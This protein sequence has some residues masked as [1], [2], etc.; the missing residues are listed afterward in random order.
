MFK[1]HFPYKNIRPT[2]E[3]ILES[4][5]KIYNSPKKYRYIVIEAGTGI[6]KSALAKSISNKEG[7]AYLLTATKQLQDQYVDDFGMMGA[8]AVKGADNYRCGVTENMTCG[9][10]ECVYDG[11]LRRDCYSKKI[12]PYKVAKEKAEASEL[13]VTSYAYFM[14]ASRQQRIDEEGIAHKLMKKRNAMIVDECHMLEDMLINFAGFTIVPSDLIKKYDLANLLDFRELVLFKK[15]PNQDNQSE[16]D[17]WVTFIKGKLEQKV[18]IME[19]QIHNFKFG[20]RSN[21][22]A[23]ELTD[24][25]D[26]DITKELRKENVLTSLIEKISAYLRMTEEQRQDWVLDVKK[27]SISAKPIDVDNLF[28]KYI[29]DFA[30]NVVVF[31]SATILDKETFCK[32]MGLDKNNTAFIMRDGV[33]EPDKSPIVYIPVGSMSYAKQ[34]DT[35]PK[36]IKEIKTLLAQHPNEKGIIHTSTYAIAQKIVEEID[37]DRLLYKSDLSSNEVLLK[38]H[39]LS[40]KPTVLVSPSLMAGVDLHDELSRFQIV[41]KMPYVSLSDER[42]KKKMKKNNR[43][44]TCKMLRNLV[45]ECGRSTRNENDWAVTYILDET[46][47]NVLK[48][49][50]KYLPPSF[51]KRVRD[52][53]NF[54]LD[55]Y[56][57][58]YKEQSK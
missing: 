10:G 9:H 1:K 17:K 12:C 48:Y 47:T 13:Y 33:F 4:L 25:S 21:L 43:W 7:S 54:D 41:V 16:F 53:G 29:N 39:E 35:M 5:D 24:M 38:E 8:S 14:K 27:D 44:Y 2:Q 49:N 46:F 3:D 31:M 23:D 50:K 6:G 45:Q 55:S 20:D 57:A 37:S 52:I 22:S 58:K 36:M 11:S 19:Q 28:Q 15:L 26:F 42:V 56:Y 40:E 51:L 18:A 30:N 34:A 32:D